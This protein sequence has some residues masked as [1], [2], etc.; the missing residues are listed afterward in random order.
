MFSE[1][2]DV[3]IQMCET[4]RHASLDTSEISQPQTRLRGLSNEYIQWN[5]MHNLSERLQ[6]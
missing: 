6:Q 3:A 5:T 4:K 2:M 1:G